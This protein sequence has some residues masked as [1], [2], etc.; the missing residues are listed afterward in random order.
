MFK[1]FTLYLSTYFNYLFFFKHYLKQ[2]LVAVLIISVCVSFMDALSLSVFIPLFD[3]ANANATAQA[4]KLSS[5]F[6]QLLDF[7]QLPA[8]INSVLL[9]MVVFLSI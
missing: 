8:T 4:S 1:Q 7:L 9:I 2:K 3:V 6:R 5:L